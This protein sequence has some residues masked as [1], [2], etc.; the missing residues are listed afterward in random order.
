[1]NAQHTL[2]LLIG[3]AL[4][5][6]VAGGAMVF[7][8]GEETFGRFL[9]LFGAVMQ[10]PLLALG[11]MYW[12]EAAGKAAALFAGVAIAWMI[13]VTLLAIYSGPQPLTVP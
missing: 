2:V 6:I 7:V 1:M 4:G 13:V 11:V 5:L 3:T 12:H 9:L 10:I 8:W